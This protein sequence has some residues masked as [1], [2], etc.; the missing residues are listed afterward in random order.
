M[1]DHDKEQG[2]EDLVQHIVDSK[3]ED[4]A[5]FIVQVGLVIEDEDFWAYLMV[6]A[7]KYEAFMAAQ[8]KGLCNIKE[9]GDI[10]ECGPG[11][12]APAEVLQKIQDEFG[13][14]PQVS[15]SL[16]DMADTLEERLNRMGAQKE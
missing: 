5:G 13:I 3:D 6:P 4:E 8:Q 15:D 14:M 10:I 2:D 7:E 16:H 1:D 12:E 11:K 9:Y